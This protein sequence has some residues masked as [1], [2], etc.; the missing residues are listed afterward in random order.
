ML[1]SSI[2]SY[3]LCSLLTANSNFELTGFDIVPVDLH[4]FIAVSPA[5]L[6]PESQ[7]VKELV[8]DSA[9]SETA[10]SQTEA[11]FRPHTTDVGPAS[12]KITGILLLLL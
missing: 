12:V 1:S 7:S 11:L 6:V 4:V 3:I 2:Y 9:M 8:L 10:E 5:L